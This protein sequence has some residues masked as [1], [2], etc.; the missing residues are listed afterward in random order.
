MYKLQIE[1]LSIL[2]VEPSIPQRK[3]IV[4]KLAG[5]GVKNVESVSDLP[6]ALQKLANY[7]PDLVVS[8]MYLPSGTGTELITAMRE[9]SRL[10]SIP[11]MLVSSET[12]FEHL[13]PIRQAGV[14]AILPKP[15][16]GDE[17]RQ[18]LQATLQYIESD[19][20]DLE[21]FD[22]RDVRMLLV[23]DSALAR[24][25]I[26]RVLEN[27]GAVRITEAADGW[28]AIEILQHDEFDLV[29]S[30]YNMPH[31]DGEEL[32]RY[33]RL[34]SSQSYLPVIM[35]TSE[36][37]QAKLSSIQQSGVSALCDKPFDTLHVK[38]LLQQLL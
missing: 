19:D 6:E 25:H 8:A 29:V 24:K 18:A 28:E 9:N 17:L 11:F 30:D 12:K 13:D 37:N 10:E 34:K 38:Q 7:Q 22:I 15:F 32:L 20:L 31:V 1:E 21:S 16:G 36:Q 2:L 26:R 23:D 4:A 33:I 3:I 5:S 27:M 14:V 35:V